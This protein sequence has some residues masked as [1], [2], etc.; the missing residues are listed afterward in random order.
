MAAFRSHSWPGNVREVQNLVER[1]V[2]LANNGLLAN[3]L[4]APANP[5]PASVPQGVASSAGSTK[6]RDW[7]RA[8][9]LQTLNEVGWVVGGRN[10]AAAKLG[11][12]RTTLIHR[13]KKLQIKKPARDDILQKLPYSALSPVN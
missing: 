6:L 4:T 1:A 10:G 3:P 2:I 5:F 9:I 11:L 8:F 12:N 13:M 7:E